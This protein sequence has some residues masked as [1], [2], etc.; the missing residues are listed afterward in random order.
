MICLPIVALYMLLV[1]GC[2][3]VQVLPATPTP[4]VTLTGTSMPTL[5][6]TLMPSPT[7]TNTPTPT[8]NPFASLPTP[9]SELTDVNGTWSQF[10]NGNDVTNLLFHKDFL[11]TGTEGGVM[12]WDLKSGESLK[13]TTLDGLG[14]NNV[15]ALVAGPDGVLWFG[16]WGGGVSRYD[17]A[18]NVW[19]TITKTDGLTD[20]HVSD[21]A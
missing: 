8:P 14:D 4:T 12:V 1:S 16:T 11:W 17:P 18:T 9:A 15:S 2:D 21:I 19:H 13:Y 10:T 5:T 6:S 20:N 7:T 3:T